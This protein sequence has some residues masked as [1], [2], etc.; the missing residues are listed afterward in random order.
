MPFASKGTQ[1]VFVA[2]AC[3][4]FS[5]TA[6]GQSRAPS[7]EDATRAQLLEMG[8]PGEAIELARERVLEILQTRNSCS[9]WFGESARDPAATFGSL[10]FALDKNGPREVIGLINGAGVLLF[11]HPYSGSTVT[12]A[13]LHAVITINANGPFFVRDALVM[14][15]EL[16][17]SAPRA[18]GWRSLNVASY[19]GRSMGAQ[20]TT[21][22]HELGHVIGRLPDDSDEMSGQSGRNT[23][24]VLRYCRGEVKEAE[25]RARREEKE[26]SAE[27]QSSA[28][29]QGSSGAN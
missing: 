5:H 26:A 7:S 21:L 25:R 22:L 9:A 28:N 18:A 2:V 29:R 19:E 27:K 15:Q 1:C 8:K 16:P 3:M 13:G 24:Q 4:V 17:G 6:F 14:K 11:K 23:L 10:Q 12:R 20:V